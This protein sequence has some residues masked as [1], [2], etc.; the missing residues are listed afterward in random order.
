MYCITIIVNI[1]NMLDKS[2]LSKEIDLA[3]KVVDP[4]EEIKKHYFKSNE[5]SIEYLK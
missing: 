3:V 1:I 4:L 5:I 2:I